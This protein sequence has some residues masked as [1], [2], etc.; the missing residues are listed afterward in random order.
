M[1]PVGPD[2]PDGQV[3][4]GK[5]VDNRRSAQAPGWERGVL[6]AL[7]AEAI[8]TWSAISTAA[9]DAH[10]REIDD[11]NVFPVP[12][13][14]TG[15]N[16]ALTLHSA[17]DALAASGAADAAGA[18]HAYARGAVLGARG[19][20]GVIISQLLRGIA[21]AAD[22]VGEC[23]AAVLRSALIR[24]AAQAR[25]AVAEPVD[26]TILTVA[27]AAADALPNGSAS[28]A[29]LTSAAVAAAQDAL[30]HTP[31]QLPALAGAGVVDAGGRGL[32][33]VL[34]ALARTVGARL[35]RSTEYPVARHTASGPGCGS[36]AGSYGFEVQYLL[37][38][39]ESAMAGLRERLSALGDSVAIVG[40]GDGVWN[41]HVHVDDIGAAIEAGVEAGRPYEIAVTGLTDQ[42]AHR[43]P[44]A[45]GTAVVA[46]TSGQ[47][48]S[49][50]FAG[51][52]VHVVDAAIGPEPSAG[53]LS[54]AVRATGAAEV[55]LLPNAAEL[56]GI[57]EAAAAALRADAVRVTVVPTR[58][59]V[60]GL[61]AIAVHD[62]SRRFEDD[63]VAMAEAAAATRYA[64]LTYARQESLTSVGVCRAGDTLGL[65]DGEVVEIGHSLTAVTSALLERLLGIG[66]EL[67]TVLVGADMPADFGDRVKADALQRAPLTEVTV[68][69]SGQQDPQL[70][71]G[72]E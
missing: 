49:R 47:A 27:R 38:A 13:R 66:A 67:L 16:L 33:L 8:R 34:E 68:Y 5:Q 2:S 1:P 58:S 46:V 40:T 29:E 30:G 42:F 37:H 60:Q 24:G 14:D 62:G 11:L 31:E 35:E 4:C 59:P 52:G 28:L 6:K 26:G 48:L 71:I 39:P 53:E 50:L 32:V 7:D 15:T 69:A 41:V 43:A 10:R 72:A 70:I 25:A 22:G 56:T 23:D 3:F 65:I 12:D 21:E 20:S 63:V 51:E 36:E 57:A 61:A 19:N 44:D 64:E 55:V 18:L 17:A 9:L 45:A 54:D